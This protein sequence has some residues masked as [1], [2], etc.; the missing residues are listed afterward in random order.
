MR[1]P[2]SL[3]CMAD[4]HYN[5]D[6]DMGV[7][8]SLCADLAK[9]IDEDKNRT[10]WSPDYIVIAGDVADKNGGYEQVKALIDKLREKKNFN[11]PEDHVIVVPGNHDVVTKCS[12]TD[13]VK[14]K[15]VFDDFCESCNDATISDF[16]DFFKAKFKEFIDFSE[17]YTKELKY[18]SQGKS[19]I[20]S[21]C[22]QSLSGVKVM[23][24]DHVCFLYVNTEWLY[25]PGRSHTKVL[26]PMCDDY[27]NYMIV[28]ENCP[29]CAPLIKDA[30]DL[31]HNKYKDY[32]VV[33]VMHRGFEHLSWKQKNIS[34]ATSIDAID[35][36][37]RTS[38]IIIT[39][40]DHV[41]APMSPTL[42]KN[43]VQHFQ[44]GAVGI[45]E[46]ST[47]EQPR[48]A[49]IIRLNIPGESVEQLFIY[50]DKHTRYSAWSFVES[51]YK[52]PMFSK[53]LSSV[54]QPKESPLY[55]DTVIRAQSSSNIDIEK[56]LAAYF[57]CPSGFIFISEHATMNIDQILNNKVV[58]GIS[59]SYFVVVYYLLYE[60]AVGEK[61]K[62]AAITDIKRKLDSFRDKNIDDVL[63]GQLII[64]EVV[65]DYPLD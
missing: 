63:S 30:C 16:G 62:Y 3:L 31:I 22:I 55:R 11:I 54:A 33:T 37:L 42:I 5:K 40:H 39:G 21:P 29:L 12:I 36:L 44:L 25:M 9:F 52:F 23:E 26:S 20:M 53:Y 4:I 32:T 17:L 45:R 35:Y 65:V 1:R 13:M 50:S 61:S 10:K 14:A 15:K 41:F 6:G 59:K 7:V 2:I 24:K 49:E 58:T 48:S 19:C 51:K 64:N 60:Y 38:D 56:A 46:K 28:D 8:D 27:S 47:K 34:D 57:Q 18:N 43:R